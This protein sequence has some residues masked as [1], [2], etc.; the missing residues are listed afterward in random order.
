[1][2]E[3]LTLDDKWHHGLNNTVAQFMGGWNGSKVQR[4][5][6]I[7]YDWIEDQNGLDQFLTKNW[8]YLDLVKFIAGYERFKNHGGEGDSMQYKIPEVLRIFDFPT[9]LMI[10]YPDPFRDI[11]N[12]VV[13]FTAI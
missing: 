13:C 5:E 12:G 8:K 4:G 11:G 6:N 7:T 1:M 2:L 9:S 3:R 10:I